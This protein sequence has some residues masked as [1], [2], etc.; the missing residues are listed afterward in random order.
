MELRPAAICDSAAEEL[1]SAVK[2]GLMSAGHTALLQIG[3]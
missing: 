3:G 1:P 2:G